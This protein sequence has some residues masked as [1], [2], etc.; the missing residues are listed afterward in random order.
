M[1]QFGNCRFLAEIIQADAPYDLTVCQFGNCQFL[2]EII[3]AD[4]PYDLTGFFN[5][6]R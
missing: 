5:G 1:R 6:V 2:A 3:Q 4:A